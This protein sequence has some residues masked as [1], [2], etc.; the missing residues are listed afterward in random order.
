MADEAKNTIGDTSLGVPQIPFDLVEKHIN[1]TTKLLANSGSE[2]A[3]DA[4]N[5]WYDYEFSR[6]LFIGFLDIS[7]TDLSKYDEYEFKVKLAD[8]GKRSLRA[9]P[10]DG[11]LR[12]DIN[13]FCTSIS[14]KPPSIYWTIFKRNPRLQK[15]SIHGFYKENLNDFLY[16]ITRTTKLKND[17]IAEIEAARKSTNETIEHLNAKE[18]NLAN[19]ESEIEESNRTL[20]TL[21]ISISEKQ[22]AEA[23]LQAQL[24][25]STDRLDTFNESIEERRQELTTVTKNREAEKREVEKARL[26]L[27]RL[28][29]DIN[30]FPSEISGFVTQASKDIGTYKWFIGSMVFVI[31]ALFVWVLTGAFDLSEYIK[32]NPNV[33]VWP[34]LLAKLPL[35]TV[36]SAIVAA[37]YKISKV[38]IEELLKINRQK[39]SLTQV[40]IVAKDVSQAAE[41]ELELSEVQIYGL[42]L[43]TKMA[44]LAD[45]I[46]T[47]IPTQP[48]EL[49]PQSI[50]S[51]FEVRRNKG[52]AEAPGKLTN[53]EEDVES[54]AG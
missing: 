53:D 46:K 37:A 30:L 52:Q 27:K 23:E 13:E 36:V 44:M 49:L 2:L 40:S 43:R 11:E 50:F 24:D 39:L 31:F 38:F 32:E 42:R 19:I 9:K 47:F 25:R 22:A 4:K 26:D 54:T 5:R 29:E 17:A 15:V 3:I 10:S 20:E 45:H 1:K 21:N 8:G 51:A 6:P 41:A 33:D 16:K 18:Q 35:A 48:N 34:L 28:K 14:F 12:V 7:G